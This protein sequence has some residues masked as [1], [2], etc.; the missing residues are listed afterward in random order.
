MT[1]DSINMGKRIGIITHYYDSHNIGGLLQAYA[2]CRKVS[3][4]GF[5]AEQICYL[6]K[7]VT[8]KSYMLAWKIRLEQ[9]FVTSPSTLYKKMS[10]KS[11][12]NKCT[13][14]E[15]TKRKIQIQWNRFKDFEKR[16][17]HSEKVFSDATVV[18]TNNNYDIFI[19]GS[20]VIWHPG[21]LMHPTYYLQF[22]DADKK[23]I[24]YAASMG[25][26]PK[27]T[28]EKNLFSMR[29]K[30]IQQISVRERSVAE[31]IEENENLHV[32]QVL[33][34]T[35]LLNEAEWADIEAARNVPQGKY[36]FCY[37]LGN[38][39]SS[40]T[41]T[42]D[43]CMAKGIRLIYLPYIMGCEREADEQLKK[44]AHG[45]YDFGPEDVI[46]LIHYADYIFTDSFHAVV[47]ST[48]FRKRFFAFDRDD[49]D[50][51][52]SI[53]GRI[54]DFLKDYGMTSCHVGNGDNQLQKIENNYQ[55]WN[56]IQSNLLKDR[57]ESLGYLKRVLM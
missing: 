28:I 45:I 53:N 20:D 19:C 40:R 36:A 18:E 43:F 50:S 14:D 23:A 2:L 22:V 48:I 21:N 17:P 54:N 10:E 3:E 6:P 5:Q 4:F 55:N 39:I 12:K 38:S 8:K 13:D 52:Y 32:E 35:L 11:R 30:N 15:N 33:D 57:L 37:F 24:A 7:L 26:M 41:V 56:E 31:Y 9:A 42:V 44:Y 46:A 29:I 25:R 34:P 16:I 1:S 47:F 51:V 27:T 49:Q